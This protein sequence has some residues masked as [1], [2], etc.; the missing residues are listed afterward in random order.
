VEVHPEP[1]EQARLLYAAFLR[2]EYPEERSYSMM[3]WAFAGHTLDEARA[4]AAR[5]I[6]EVSLAARVQAEIAPILRWSADRDVPVYVVSASPAFVVRTAVE[7]LGLSVSLVL[8]MSPLVVDGVL[9]AR[10][11]EPLTYGA[12][13]LA[14]LHAAVPDKKLLAAF[15]DSAFD[16]PMLG[17]ARVSVAVRPKPALVARAYTVPGIVE[18][19]PSAP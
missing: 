6:A 13:K 18:L 11:A 16:L 14:A 15:G 8:G 7:L 12:G 5:V 19:S 17:E 3:A 9:S 2:G 4:F 10:C 1:T